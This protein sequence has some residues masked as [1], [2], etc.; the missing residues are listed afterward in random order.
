MTKRLLLCGNDEALLETR[1]AILAL[2]GY[3]VTVGKPSI[4]SKMAEVQADLLILCSS[5]SRDEQ[6]TLLE[7]SH[8]SQPTLKT[9]IVVTGR[10]DDPPPSPIDTPFFAFDGPERFVKQCRS[11]L[12]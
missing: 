11:L 3:D 4:M 9:L 8:E 12:A 1:R 2:E 6:R 10:Q 5:L 7:R